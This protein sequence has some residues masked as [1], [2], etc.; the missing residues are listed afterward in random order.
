MSRISRLDEEAEGLWRAMS[1]E[2]Q[3]EGLRGAELIAAAMS[4]KAPV[5]YDR[6]HSPHLRPT[7]IV[8]PR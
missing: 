4:L 3:P 8:R 2:P 6:I 5:Q 7:Q 1:T